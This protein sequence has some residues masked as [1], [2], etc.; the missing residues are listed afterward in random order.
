MS[1]PDKEKLYRQTEV[2][3]ALKGLMNVYWS[4][5][6][7]SRIF[8]KPWHDA[9]AT[10]ILVLGGDLLVEEMKSAKLF[11]DIEDHLS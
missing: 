7:Y 11:D 1:L 9:L 8:F 10:A 6:W 4:R 5:P 2:I 3:Q